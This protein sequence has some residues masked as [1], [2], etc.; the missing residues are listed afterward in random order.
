[1]SA[2]ETLEAPATASQSPADARE[3]LA[4][5]FGMLGSAHEGERAAA[6]RAID[7]AMQSGGMSWGDVAAAIAVP[8]CGWR[9]AS[10]YHDLILCG[11][12]KPQAVLLR[13]EPQSFP[14]ELL[15]P[16][17]GYWSRSEHA[18]LVVGGMNKP[19]YPSHFMLI[20][21]FTGD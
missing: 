1:M 15:A 18:W 12:L 17:V 6:L 19:I 13:F 10:V 5:L 16:V 3:R 7:K 2:V 14:R 8:P 9:D 11:E 20:P 21:K 4:K